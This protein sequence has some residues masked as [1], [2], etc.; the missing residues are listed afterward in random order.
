M[1]I[2]IGAAKA[3]ELELAAVLALAV[4][5]P[6]APVGVVNG[7]ELAVELIAALSSLSSG[8]ITLSITCISPL[9]VLS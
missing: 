3:L 9:F 1:L 4:A 5:E 6:S 8:D 2:T 7:P